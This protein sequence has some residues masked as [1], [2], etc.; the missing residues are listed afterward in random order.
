[1]YCHYPS[2]D[3]LQ[4]RR[5]T[6]GTQGA[7]ESG[8][9]S[10]SSSSSD[11]CKR[12]A[13]THTFEQVLAVVAGTTLFFN[14]EEGIAEAKIWDSEIRRVQNATAVADQRNR[15]FILRNT[16]WADSEAKCAAVGA[17]ICAPQRICRTQKKQG[18][19]NMVC[20]KKGNCNGKQRK[21]LKD[22]FVPAVDS[23]K[24]VWVRMRDCLTVE[25][26]ASAKL[27]TA[28]ACCDKKDKKVTANF[29]P[30]IIKKAQRSGNNAINKKKKDA[31]YWVHF[32]RPSNFSSFCV[33]I[34]SHLRLEW[35]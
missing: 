33:P 21:N 35:H 6:R 15:R 1:V 23:G 2:A 7:Q 9:S 18:A 11:P 20:S 12:V 34:C 17:E 3:E 13:Y 8:R 16:T 22:R 30:S 4:E 29:Q 24:H 5:N 31:D 28:V 10:S 14:M 32:L 19:L 27:M 25:K 26:P